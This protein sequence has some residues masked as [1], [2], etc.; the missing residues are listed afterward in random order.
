MGGAC[1]WSGIGR[2]GSGKLAGHRVD[3]VAEPRGVVT[4][5]ARGIRPL[6]SGPICFPF[7]FFLLTLLLTLRPI[8]DPPLPPT[9][10]PW[11]SLSNL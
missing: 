8:S 7:F 3:F 5:A 6:T 2:Q 11:P 1:G 9:L 4:A 10:H